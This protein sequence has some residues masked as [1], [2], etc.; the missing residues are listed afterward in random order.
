MAG[1]IEIGRPPRASFTEMTEIALP[2]HTNAAGSVFGGTVMGW[3]D[4]CAA[5]T[6]QRHCRR[7]AVTAAV[8][9]LVFLSPIK[10]GDIV[11]LTAR[12]NAVFKSSMEIEV[13]VE[14]EDRITAI[15]TLCVQSFLTYVCVGPDGK[16]TAVPPLV[17]ETEEEVR[18][19]M[20]GRARREAR[21]QRKRGG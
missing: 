15:R 12:V 21:L 13:Q 16:P 10:V 5:I 19:D 18:R 6:A 11:R 3:I 20:Q 7:V 9:D 17:L 14:I 1:E 4:V 2:Q 8:D